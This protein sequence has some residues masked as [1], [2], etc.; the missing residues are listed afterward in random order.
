MKKIKTFEKKKNT[1]ASRS[2]FCKWKSMEPYINYNFVKLKE[3]KEKKSQ[4][5]AICKCWMNHI[6]YFLFRSSIPC[7]Q[8]LFGWEETR[9]II[10]QCIIDFCIVKIYIMCT[11]SFLY[12]WMY[13][14][15][16]MS[17]ALIRPRGRQRRMG[18]RPQVDRVATEHFSF[19]L[20]YTRVTYVHYINTRVYV[21]F[22]CLFLDPMLVFLW[23][24]QLCYR[25]S[26]FEG[27]CIG[28]IFKP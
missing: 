11:L 9:M 13:V 7:L 19:S 22:S 26:V 18:F 24:T 5:Y 6:W 25:K 10:S 17:A 14:K 4:W 8:N 3:R 15:N 27:V 12:T 1:K 28:I 2:A 21:F 20:R 16:C 23:P